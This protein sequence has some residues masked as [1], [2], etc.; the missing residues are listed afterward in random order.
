MTGQALIKGSR[1][2]VSEEQRSSTP[3][4]LFRPSVRVRYE[5]SVFA[6]P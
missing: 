2:S 4:D 3:G 5:I 6:R 1:G